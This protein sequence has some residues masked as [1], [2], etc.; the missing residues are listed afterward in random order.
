MRPAEISEDRR[1]EAAERA[2][3]LVATL[4]AS[5]GRA[6]IGQLD[7]VRQVLVALLVGG[8][9]LVRGVPGLAKTLLI[10]SLAQ[11][12][13]L[14]FNRVQ[15]TP[16]LMPGDILGTE[17]LEED[18]STGRRV[19]RF[20]P[21]PVFCQVLLA[22]EIN[23]TPPKTQAALLEAMQERQ[24][25][26]AG[27]RYTLDEPFFVMATQNP[28]E[29]EGTYKLPEAELDRFLFNVTVE[30]PSLDEEERILSATTA[31]RDDEIRPVADAAMILATQRAV[32]DVVAASNVVRYAARIARATRPG[33]DDAVAAAR[34]WIA[35]GA[36]PRA[37]QALLLGAKANA[38]IEG[39]YAVTFDDIHRIAHPVLR[40]RVVPNFHAE[41]EG[42]TADTIV[43]Q[44]LADVPLE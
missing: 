16:D 1:A 14:A 10:K 35:W 2:P 5:I 8:H 41:A 25:T 39:R 26:V 44:V 24:V 17:V 19:T 9:V 15:F 13:D 3:E 36:G 38:L 22:D 11:S 37:G 18:T 23:R 32:R 29:Q 42:V 21:G 33:T 4:E 34:E 40:H 28:I 20:I 43:D 27:Q 6:V 7:V 30:Y 12:L 31:S